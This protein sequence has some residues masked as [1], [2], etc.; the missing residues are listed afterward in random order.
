MA[1]RPKY[2]IPSEMLEEIAEHGLDV[3]RELIHTLIDA[4]TLLSSHRSRN[5]RSRYRQYLVASENRLPERPCRCAARGL[6]ALSR[7][8]SAPKLHE[9]RSRDS[10]LTRPKMPYAGPSSA[11]RAKLANGWRS[12]LPASSE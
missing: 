4:A 6:S 3:V 9:M 11:S 1:Y 7:R 12:R 2:S 8:L 10:R 5:K